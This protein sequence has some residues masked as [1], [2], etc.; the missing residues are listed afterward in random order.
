MDDVR[1]DYQAL[2]QQ[3][4]NHIAL[5]TIAAFIP[6]K[7]AANMLVDTLE[8]FIQNGVPIEKAMKI[9]GELLPVMNNYNEKENEK[10]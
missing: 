2:I 5:K 7:S 10:L 4:G 8:V 1:F 6:D 3:I 9:L